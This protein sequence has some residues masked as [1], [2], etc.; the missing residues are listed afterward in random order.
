MA[1][2]IIKNIILR[3]IEIVILY[4][5]A[6]WIWDKMPEQ[7]RLWVLIAVVS[8]YIAYAAMQI[9]NEYREEVY[10]DENTL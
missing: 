7:Y 10:G 2:R 1:K 6:R 4:F 8:L 5:T 3:G 9:Y